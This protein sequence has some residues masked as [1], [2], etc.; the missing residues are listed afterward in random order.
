MNG[1]SQ[2]PPLRQEAHAQ[3]LAA[4]GVEMEEELRSILGYWMRQ[5][6][7]EEHGGFY[8]KIDG[9]NRAHPEAPKGVVLNSRICWAF[10]AAYHHTGDPQWLSVATRAHDYLLA[11]FLDPVY[12]GVYWSVDYRGGLLN[13]R[14]QIYG[15]AFCLYGLSEYCIANKQGQTLEQAI[16]LF[17]LIEERSYD[18]R[19][20]GYYE[21][22]TRDWQPLEDLRLSPKDANERKTMNTHLHVIEAYA[23]LY[24][25]WP[26]A[27]LRQRITDLLE[28]FDH[29]IVDRKTGHL[30]L[31]FDEDW[32]PRSD[33]LSF[34]HDI[35]A[36]WL[37]QEAAVIVGDSHWVATTKEWAM[38]TADAA[39]GGLDKDGGLWY[40]QEGGQLV[41]EK[42]SWPQA[43]AMVGFF[44]AWQISGDPRWL[45]RSM[46]SWKFVK[47][48][49]K[50]PV[51]GEWF[52]G[53]RADHSPMPGQ[54]KAGFWKCPYHNSRACLEIIRRI[55]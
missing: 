21:A 7:D 39:A 31:F 48:Y 43:E 47:K 20:K 15:L 19:R 26:D 30:V 55:G 25:V 23:N 27:L 54:D 44:N 22:F 45:D 5:T 1:G 38:K 16:S 14:K 6:I 32:N 40:E 4:Y 52:W 37:L 13:G 12:G 18:T 11:H 33:I 34:G 49:I 41:M 29:Y 50:D 35:E 8:G 24:R 28:V 10:S 51:F 17:R 42:H 2:G 36:A 9:D 53:V 46:D 3:T